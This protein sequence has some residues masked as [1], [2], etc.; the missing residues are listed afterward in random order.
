[1]SISVR[2][3][4]GILQFFPIALR[5]K[6]P[7]CFENFKYALSSVPGYVKCMES[8]GLNQLGLRFIFPLICW[9]ETNYKGI[10]RMTKKVERDC[11]GALIMSNGFLQPEEAPES[12]FNLINFHM[13]SLEPDLDLEQF[14]FLH[15][16]MQSDSWGE[17][18]GP[19]F[20][21]FFPTMF[22][23]FSLFL[24]PFCS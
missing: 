21:A 20:S 19:E 23:H 18:L 22:H 1:M 9:L 17:M 3:K 6:Y 7:L 13:R 4:F 14:N 12:S 11:W 2:S 16:D 8:C 15:E 10:Y 24:S 5:E